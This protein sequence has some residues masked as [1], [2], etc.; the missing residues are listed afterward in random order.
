MVSLLRAKVLHS[1]ELKKNP[2]YAEVIFIE[3]LIS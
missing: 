2:I 3:F 1:C